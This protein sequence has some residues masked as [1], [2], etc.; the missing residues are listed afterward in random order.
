VPLDEA[1]RRTVEWE[2]ANP[3]L[4]INPQQFDYAAE[5]AAM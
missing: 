5:D 4:A 1:I 2:R 3:P